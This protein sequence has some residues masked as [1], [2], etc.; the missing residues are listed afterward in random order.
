MDVANGPS[1]ICTDA[2]RPIWNVS[3]LRHASKL[4]SKYYLLLMSVTAQLIDPSTPLGIVIN[5][6]HTKDLLFWTEI[7]LPAG[8]WDA[9]H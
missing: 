9:G 1:L 6:A 5:A 7:T 8:N 2:D 4:A 3:G